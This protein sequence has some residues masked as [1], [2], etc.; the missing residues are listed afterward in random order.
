M[1][2]AARHRLLLVAAALLFSTGGAGIK[3]CSVGPWSIA[4]VRAVVAGATVLALMPASRRRPSLRVLPVALAYAGLGLLFV[5]ANRYTSA[6]AT[7]FLQASSPLYIVALG[8]W[9]LGERARGRDLV[10]LATLALAVTVMFLGVDTPTRTAPAPLLG[11]ALATA[12]ALC[13]AAM[14]MGLRWLGRD[15]RDAG[16]APA[17]VVM[18]NLV[19]CLVSLPFA[20]AAPAPGLGDLGVL[21][22][23]GVFQLGLPYTL[24]VEGLRH[25]PALEASLL[26]FVEP[27]FSPV[28]AW[29]AHGERP[30][31]WSMLGG[32]IILV[33]TAVYAWTDRGP[34]Q[35]IPPTGDGR[36][37]PSGS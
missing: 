9:L 21:L 14:M 8:P 3:A 24:T 5:S 37:E 17:A 31:A 11:N 30:G 22:L 36:G 10:F 32:A 1:R 29:L 28:W 35:G 26:M 27:V 13:S 6:A 18:G 20:L 4:C 23:L 2:P 33:A 15:G 34:A 12:S 19:A 25:V 7:I 16:A